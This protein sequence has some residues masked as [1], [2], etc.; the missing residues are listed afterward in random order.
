M[1]HEGQI[2]EMATGEGK[3]LVAVLAAYLNALPGT[4]TNPPVFSSNS[5]ASPGSSSSSVSPGPPQR[6]H[7]AGVHVVTVNDYLAAR[8]AEW[9]G[10][11]YRWVGLYGLLFQ[12]SVT[13]TVWNSSSSTS[14]SPTLL[15]AA[16]LQC[17]C[18]HSA[19]GRL[20]CAVLCCI[21]QVP[22]SDCWH[23]TE[24]HQH[25]VSSGCLQLSHH[26]RDRS[27]AVL[28]LPQG[29]HSTVSSRAGEQVVLLVLRTW[30]GHSTGS[31]HAMESTGASMQHNDSSSNAMWQLA[32]IMR[33]W[34]YVALAACKSF[35]N[36]FVCF[37][38]GRLICLLPAPADAS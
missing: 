14:S 18:T 16:A 5:S 22:G 8:D 38:C 10:K 33:C 13:R 15:H 31:Q 6:A 17:S 12:V 36:C 11:V 37:V 32:G 35:T 4:L 3:T 28:Q 1:L 2:A 23:S 34:C 30:L 24:Q 25:R 9:M 19:P 27:G 7:G 26:I 21:V 20:C 29:Q